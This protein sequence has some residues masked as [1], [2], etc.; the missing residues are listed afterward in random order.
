MLPRVRS[1]QKLP[2][3]VGPRTREAA[4][5]C[6]DHGHADR[7]GGEVLHREAGHLD[8]ATHGRLT[9]VVLPVGV[10]DERRGGVP[11]QVRLD[12]VEAQGE[13]QQLLNPLQA[14]EE[15]HRGEGEPQDREAV[16]RPGLVGIGVDP[17]QAVQRSL[18]PAVLRRGV[19]LRHVVAQRDMRD[20]QDDD[21]REDG[22]QPG[23]GVADQ[24]LS[25]EE[26]RKHQVTG[27]QDRQHQADE[28]LGTHSRSSPLRTR[29]RTTKTRIVSATRA[30]SSTTHLRDG[31][32]PSSIGAHTEVRGRPS[33]RVPNAQ[34]SVPDAALTT[35]ADARATRHLPE[36]WG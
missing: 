16:R 32:R 2:D 35:S 13:R 27:Q 25:G 14:V 26:Q 24:N 28:V 10:G 33:S 17:A 20:A 36:G 31:N 9:G 34:P 18:G 3:P 11:R 23:R 30:T 6:H 8:E 29:A 4:H 5:Q 7:R 19:D 1:T 22:E 12:R 21:E 15:Q